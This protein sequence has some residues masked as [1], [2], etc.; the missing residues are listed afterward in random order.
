MRPI[1]GICGAIVVT[2]CLAP[3]VRASDHL[4]LLTGPLVHS[5]ITANSAQ[6]AV[7]QASET[8]TTAEAPKPAKQHVTTQH[9]VESTTTVEPPKPP[10]PVKQRVTTQH[11]VESTTT[12]EPPKP[13]KP[14]KQHVTKQ[15]VVES[16][17][18]VEVPAR[19]AP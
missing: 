17:T 13:A 1:S 10:K 15:H 9:V 14:A 16:T 3:G 18:T 19:E 8:T 12:V 4:P 6:E 7:G 2:V 5:N 11:V